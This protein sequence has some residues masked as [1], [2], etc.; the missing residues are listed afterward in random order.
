MVQGEPF[1]GPGQLHIDVRG[2][3]QQVRPKLVAVSSAAADDQGQCRHSAGLLG[4]QCV[5]S[6]LVDKAPRADQGEER[7][8]LDMHRGDVR[9]LR[10]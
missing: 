3:R 9:G 5:G 6:R 8:E 2:G 10:W 1:G 4:N 7:S